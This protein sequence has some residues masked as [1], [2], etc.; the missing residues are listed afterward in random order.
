MLKS[1]EIAGFKSFA[2]KTELHFKSRVT[3]IV[4]PNGSGKSNV[5][6]AFRFAL[7]EQSIKSMR[8]KRG[9]DLIWNGST[10]IGRSNRANVKLVFDNSKN[11]F[12]LDFEEIVI[13]RVVNRD[14]GNEYYLNGSLVRLKDIFELLSQAH[15]GASG[16]HIISQGEA[17]RILSANIKER[18]EMI[19]DALGLKIY[20]YKREESE[21]KLLKTEE[22]IKQ[23]ESLR[24]EIAPH[25]KFLK[26]QA[27]KVEKAEELRVKLSKF[28]REYLKR[29][30]VYIESQNN[31]IKKEKEPIVGQLKDLNKKME[32]AKEILIAS[33]SK[34]QKSEELLNTE[35]EIKKERENKDNLY[36]EVGK[37]EGEINVNKRNIEKIETDQR[38]EEN[39][40]IPLKEVEELEKEVSTYLEITKIIEKIRNFII[41]HR[42]KLDN[43]H[44]DRLNEENDSLIKI[45]VELED[46]IMKVEES[47]S[48]LSSKYQKIK[49]SI[50]KEKDSSREA[51]KTMFKISGEQSNLRNRLN[52]LEME[53]RRVSS[54]EEDWKRE[55]KEGGVLLGTAIL[56]FENDEIPNLEEVPASA[57]SYGVAREE[58]RRE[59]EKMKIRLEELGGGEGVEVMKE[60][61]DSIERDEFLLKELEDLKNSAKSLEQLIKELL[62]KLDVEFKQG[63]EKINKSF[64]EF[65][66]LMFGGGEAKLEIVKSKKVRKYENLE[67]DEDG[68]SIRTN[69][70]SM[71]DALDLPSF[72]DGDFGE[73]MGGIDISVSLP[74]KR[75]KGLEMLS[76]GE[77]AL[78]SIA[79][80]FA[81]SAVNPP[82]FIILDE[83]DAALDEANS[84]KYG[85]MIESLS[86]VS[87]LILITH[88]RETMSRAG[89]IYGVTMGR[90]GVSRLLS[91]AFDE[92]VAVAK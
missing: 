90:D 88:N 84:K 36:R 10:E 34:D 58:K 85:D 71:L 4:G 87:Q 2:K 12:S 54:L 76:G 59:L 8:G 79:L 26:K 41:S 30:Q 43:K 86:K 91:I 23:V 20:Q 37:I 60:Y 17:D 16:H 69:K 13:E 11:L 32:E 42:S 48:E 77:R 3:A 45:K 51:E 65:F 27:E 39:K 29:E 35:N 50:E 62:L 1:L 44:L 6:E 83:T 64:H 5:A 24:R 19:E 9:E 15:I 53:T 40:T 21:R 66:S 7:G 47:L 78:T 68:E 33:E 80:L 72:E 46:K 55:I 74:R 81:V 18:K 52:I 73:A 14:G 61:K 75:T 28:Y 31:S 56:G 92:A 49:E 38:S 25:I 57:E 67:M 89:V 82:P 22:N 63:I 70:S